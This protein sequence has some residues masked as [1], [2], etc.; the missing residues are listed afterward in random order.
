MLVSLERTFRV[1]RGA[2]RSAWCF[3]LA[4]CRWISKKRSRLEGKNVFVMVLC[5]PLFLSGFCCE[6]GAAR[7]HSDGGLL[8]NLI[9]KL[10]CVK[11]IY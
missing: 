2:M 3:S 9:E 5:N 1:A 4:P 8:K 11:R 7:P 6:L 10:A